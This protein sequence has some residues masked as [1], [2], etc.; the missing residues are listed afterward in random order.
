MSSDRE[1]EWC[2]TQF[3]VEIN[4][5]C[6]IVESMIIGRELQQC[7]MRSAKAV[8][9]VSRREND[10]DYQEDLGLRLLHN[11]QFQNL[12]NNISIFTIIN[13]KI[14]VIIYK[15]KNTSIPYLM[16]THKHVHL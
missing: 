9:A 14:C 11:N 12:N 8:C 3:I 5:R 4:S 15:F 7:R 16:P 10:D 6:D 13:V 2:R 1:T